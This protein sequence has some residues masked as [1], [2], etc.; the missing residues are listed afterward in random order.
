MGLIYELTD[1]MVEVVEKMESQGVDAIHIQEIKALCIDRW[2]M[3]HMPLHAVGYM[4]HPV[5]KGRNQGS[6]I[7]VHAGWMNVLQSI[8]KVILSYKVLSLM[9]LMCIRMM[10]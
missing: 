8:Q 10:G 4:L 5:S 7:E 9:S 1:R 6:D 3:L 2:D